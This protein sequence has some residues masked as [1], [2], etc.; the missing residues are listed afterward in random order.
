MAEMMMGQMINQ[1]GPQVE[2]AIAKV[3][4]LQTKS[5]A[6]YM[7]SHQGKAEARMFVPVQPIVQIKT[8]VEEAM[9]PPAPVAP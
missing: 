9:Q 5:I 8:I 7:S 1:M 4:A 2:K 3:N 6:F